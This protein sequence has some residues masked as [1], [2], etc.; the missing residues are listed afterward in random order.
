MANGTKKDPID[1]TNDESFP[2]SDPPGWSGTH[3]GPPDGRRPVAEEPAEDETLRSVRAGASVPETVGQLE[4]TIAGAG[5]K[6]FAR[7]D[8]AEAARSVGLAMRPTVLLLFGNAKAGTPLMVA[9]P[10]VAIDLP[11]KALVW[12]DSS[13][14]TWLTYNKP[15]LL[16]KRHGLEGSLAATLGPAG[17]LLERAL[18]R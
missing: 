16:E 14:T 1:E 9:C 11:L 2:A 18:K 6:V 17:T 15:V 8:H 5:M 7:I 10:T 13:G 4:R 12:E 3:A